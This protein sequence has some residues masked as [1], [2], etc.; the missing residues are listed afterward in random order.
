MGRFDT[1]D[2]YVHRC[3]RQNRRPI[4]AC[5]LFLRTLRPQFQ[6]LL[7]PDRRD[8]FAP[9]WAVGLEQ[10]VE[11]DDP[12]VITNPYLAGHAYRLWRSRGPSAKEKSEP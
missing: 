8:A 1:L 10:V 9:N 3:W 2:A 7:S 12:V 6:E 4:V 5:R 11:E